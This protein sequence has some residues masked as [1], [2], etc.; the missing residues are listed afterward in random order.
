MAQ[1]FIYQTVTSYLLFFY[2]NVYGLNPAIAA[3]MLLVVRVIGAIWDSIVD[4]LIDRVTLPFGKYRGWMALMG[5][6]LAILMVLCFV[7]PPLAETGK[8]VYA[9]AVTYVALSMV[10]TTINVPFSALNA[11]H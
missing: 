2:T 1:D 7:V 6:P 3:T 9:A 8:V 10:Y 4:A 5:A 11:A